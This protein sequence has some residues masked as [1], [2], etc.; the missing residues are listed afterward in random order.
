MS[1]EIKKNSMV[2]YVVKEFDKYE[3]HWTPR[4]EQASKVYNAWMGKLPQRGHDWQNQVHVP[5][6]IEAEQ[7]ITPRLFTALFPTDAP[8]DVQVVGDTPVKAGVVIKNGLQHFFRT[9][10]VQGHM[11]P[12][13]SQAV[14]FGTGYAESGTWLVK[15]GWQIDI[16]TG[17]RYNGLIESRPDFGYVSFFELF[18]HPAKIYM[19]DTMPIIRRRFIDAEALKALAD[20]PNYKFEN[21]ETALKT[22]SPKHKTSIVYGSDG[23]PLESRKRDEYEI[24]EYWGPWDQDYKDEHGEVKKKKAMPYWIII[25]NRQVLVRGVP[26]PFNHQ[27]PPFIKIKLF[28]DPKPSW[29]GVGIGPIGIST[30]DRVNKIVNQRLDNVDLCLNKQ[31]VYDGN[32]TLLNK[33]SLQISKPGKF[34][35]VQ[36]INTSIK[37]WDFG[38][39][40]ASSYNEEK[41]AK[42]DFKEATGATMPLQPNEKSDQHRTAMGIQLLQGAAGMRFKPILRMMEIDGIQQIAMFFFSNLQQFMT[43]PEWLQ[44]TGEGK[45]PTP[46]L[47]RPEHLQAKVNFIPTGISETVNKEVQIG[48]LLRYKE[49]TMNDP[50]VN[51]QEINKRIAQLFGFKDIE[52][53]L[54]PQQEISGPGGMPQD[55]AQQVRQRVAEGANPEQIK[56]E[57]LGPPPAPE[58]EQGGQGAS[59]RG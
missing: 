12:T 17:D 44:I 54:V 16:Q 6:M 48:Q 9:A 5:L 20:N 2:S 14:L 59:R 51:R 30:Q 10:N 36:D 13:V 38:D 15:R 50:T 24:L 57:L 7:T 21:L 39:V 56:Q 31:G 19:W 1:V 35:K 49:V 45:P 11:L 28:E 32:D 22:E 18:P 41:L 26:N 52:K 58:Q 40:T 34:H 8:L 47:L 23:K 43:E 46:F 33:K 53:L 37:V 42:D 27:I 4:F 29:F 55:M 25:V 3:R